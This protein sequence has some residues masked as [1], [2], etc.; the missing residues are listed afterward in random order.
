MSL[1]EALML[2]CFGV[3]W[4][5]SIAKALRTRHVRG[6][7]RLFMGIIALGYVFGIIHKL[8]HSYDPLV[9]LYVFNLVMVCTDLALYFKYR[10][11]EG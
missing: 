2:I 7:S 9:W 3:S 11:R 4:P 6:K 8:R 5:L 10:D 1:F